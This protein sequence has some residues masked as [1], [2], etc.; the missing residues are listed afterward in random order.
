V[1]GRDDSQ[2]R[3]SGPIQVQPNGLLGFLQLKNRGANPSQLE[4]GVQ[5]IIDLG[6]WYRQTNIETIT[7]R[8]TG[9]LARGLNAATVPI[10]V[11]ANQWWY[12]THAGAR[13]V[14]PANELLWARLA[15]MGTQAAAPAMVGPLECNSAS[16][17]AVARITELFVYSEDAFWM[18]PGDQIYVYVSDI[19]GAATVANISLRYSVLG[20]R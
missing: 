10:E 11:P 18:Q 13:S 2:H 17:A 1:A 5:P 7:N 3:S 15:I 6:E 19:I 9:N 16:G 12:V 20:Y 4:D 8:T 14:I